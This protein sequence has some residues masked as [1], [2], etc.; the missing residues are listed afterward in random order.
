MPF[1]TGS[2]G[3]S[4]WTM[5]ILAPSFFARL[6]RP[7][8]M[9][10]GMWVSSIPGMIFISKAS[11]SSPSELVILFKI[12]SMFVLSAWSVI[13]IAS[14]PWTLYLLA[15]SAGINSPSLKTEWM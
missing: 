12:K 3:V 11:D 5:M 14:Y 7:S 9:L 15:I 8:S 6:I 10:G 13:A 1:A 2:A 4:P